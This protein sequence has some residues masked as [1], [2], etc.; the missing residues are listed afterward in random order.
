[1]SKSTLFIIIVLV[2]IFFVFLY[3]QQRSLIYFPDK[4]LLRRNFFGAEDFQ[5]IT[6]YTDDN[7]PITSWYKPAKPGKA[8]ILFFHGN[9]GHIGYRVPVAREFIKQGYG[10]FLLEYRG[11]GGNPGSPS[12]TGF[13]YDGEAA[14]HHLKSEGIALQ[15]IAILGES[16]GSGVAVE[17]ASRYPVCA[18]IL[19]SPFSSLSSVAAWHYPWI[20]IAPWDK[21][22][23][24][25]K[26]KAIRSPL[27]LFHGKQDNIVPYEQGLRLFEEA[28][29]PKEMYSSENGTHNNMKN[30]QFFQAIDEFLKSRCN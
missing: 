29:E 6:L 7:V 23:N 28:N 14:I 11:Y 18:L 2:L 21:Y 30:T 5:K 26:I 13:Y 8:T 27:L 1:M 4:S 10:V 16:I 12:E 24:L 19:Q 15:N 17:M 20:P 22:D 25:K 3:I 9:A